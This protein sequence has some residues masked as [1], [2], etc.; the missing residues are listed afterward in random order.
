MVAVSDLPLRPRKLAQTKIA[1]LRAALE[2]L[3]TRTLEA[4]P[5]K[6][7]CEAVNISEASFFNYFPKKADILIFFVQYWSLDLAWQVLREAQPASAYEAIETIFR[8]TA[9]EVQAHPGVMQ[10]IL[11][12]QAR[13]PEHA[14]ISDMSL[15][16]R[17]VAFPDRPGIETLPAVGLDSL[18]PPIID[19]AVDNGELPAASDRLAVFLGLVSIFFGVPLVLC[20]MDPSAIEQAYRQ[21]LVIYW[22]GVRATASSAG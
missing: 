2:R 1:L 11:A 5:I 20:H 10:E 9:R 22:A 18:L 15:A 14:D 7:L 3:D 4:I 21:Q 16:E 13:S 8:S 19:R 12:H 17:I 6:E